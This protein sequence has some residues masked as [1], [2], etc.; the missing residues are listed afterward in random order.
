MKRQLK[1]NTVSVE[2]QNE[3][4][5]EEK[6]RKAAK[7]QAE[8]E[9]LQS[10]AKLKRLAL[11]RE[12]EWNSAKLGHRL[13]L[14]RSKAHV[15]QILSRAK[16]AVASGWDNVV[17]QPWTGESDEETGDAGTKVVAPINGA[18]AVVPIP[19]YLFTPDL[20]DRLHDE[21][22][23]SARNA[24]GPKSLVHR[25]HRTS[26]AGG[27]ECK[28][29]DL[30][31]GLLTSSSTLKLVKSVQIH[32]VE[33]ACAVM[34]N[35][36]DS[37]CQSEGGLRCHGCL[38]LDED[39]KFPEQE[40]ARRTAADEPSIT[41]CVAG[42]PPSI[43]A[44][45]RRG[46]ALGHE[47]APLGAPEVGR[48]REAPPVYVT[49]LMSWRLQLM[50]KQARGN[51][52]TSAQLRAEDWT[53]DNGDGTTCGL[54]ERIHPC[55]C[56]KEMSYQE[57]LDWNGTFHLA[58]HG[59]SNGAVISFE[60][61]QSELDSM[62]ANRHL[63]RN[64][65]DTERWK[66]INDFIWL[67]MTSLFATTVKGGWRA[68]FEYTIDHIKWLHWALPGG[69]ARVLP[70]ATAILCAGC[71]AFDWLNVNF[72]VTDGLTL[73]WS[74]FSL[75]G[76]TVATYTIGD[77]CLMT[78]YAT[79]AARLALDYTTLEEILRAYSSWEYCRRKSLQSSIQVQ[80]KSEY[81]QLHLA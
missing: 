48:E 23:A 7:L 29:S 19:A 13:V 21:A 51:P 56:D 15:E 31:H 46:R 42:A 80:E 2:E 53:D 4:R 37:G 9:K 25:L 76:L 77:L 78:F 71:I 10:A 79:T 22:K 61:M 69:I 57:I 16:V 49:D 63:A 36:S 52:L 58:T 70:V 40:I 24:T 66:S 35:G 28:I 27:I 47:C 54:F 64:D 6:T 12:A 33:W 68:K 5:K 41:F 17:V 1:M 26:V 43:M 55:P 44:F 20:A 73:W 74:M 67:A 59:I 34:C 60:S 50:M 65:S 14:P 3:Y 38:V 8:E 81:R 11:R 18:H 30:Q 75:I 72:E 32:Y 62:L 39:A 45:V